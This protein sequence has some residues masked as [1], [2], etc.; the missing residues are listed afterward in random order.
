MGSPLVEEETVHG[1]E[2]IEGR[3]EGLFESGKNFVVSLLGHLRSRLELLGLELSQEKNRL[4]T[5]LGLGLVAYLLVGVSIMLALL[6]AIAAFWDT[7]YR[8]HVIGA[9]L[10]VALLAIGV[11]ATVLR[12]RLRQASALFK[13][14][15]RELAND[16]QMLDR[17]R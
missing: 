7:P 10:L 12:Q 15:V 17:L 9:L 13:S 14:S 4:L 6:L 2:H 8:L 5:V 16:Q 11:I 3:H 1:A